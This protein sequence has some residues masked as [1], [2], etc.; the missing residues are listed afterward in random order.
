[1]NVSNLDLSEA[2]WLCLGKLALAVELDCGKRFTF[3]KAVTEIEA[4]LAAAEASVNAEIR[5]RKEEFLQA[6]SP[7]VQRLLLGERVFEE[8]DERFAA[9]GL[10]PGE[11]YYRGAKVGQADAA[12][13]GKPA[14]KEQPAGQRYRGAKLPAEQPPAGDSA[15]PADGAVDAQGRKRIVY[16]GK[17]I[18]V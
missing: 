4:L 10:E 1:M 8:R 9:Q 15:A 6:I 3:R 7:G 16:R 12:P 13:A 2:A 14:Q 5:R 17:V 11:R 18:Y